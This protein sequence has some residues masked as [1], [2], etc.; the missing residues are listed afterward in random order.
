MSDP[1]LRIEADPDFSAAV[2]LAV[3]VVAGASR[4]RVAGPHGGALKVLVTQ[5]PEGGAANRAI[6]RLLASYLGV[7]VGAVEVVGGHGSAWKTLRLAGL[8]PEQVRLR[9]AQP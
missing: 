1:E 5:P 7:P 8:T 4:E 6:C 3:K 9:L 2:R